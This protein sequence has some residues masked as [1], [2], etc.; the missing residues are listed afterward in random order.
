M[1]LTQNQRQFCKLVKQDLADY[2]G[3]VIL[4]KG[5]FV[6]G[7]SQCC[8]IFYFNAKS[9]PIIKVAM[10]KNSRDEW[11][12]VLVHEYAHFL[13]WKF[14]SKIWDKFQGGDFSFDTL[15]LDPIKNRRKILTMIELEMDCERKAISLIK[16]FKLCN[17]VRLYAQQANA[18]LYKY[19]Y[20]YKYARWPVAN[21]RSVAQNLSVAIL[22]TAKDYL[23][24][25]VELKDFL[26]NGKFAKV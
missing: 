16:R 19:A 6:G 5:E 25:P 9:E 24:I 14:A 22:P 12:G 15:I 11:F 26:S 2:D 10:G 23:S 8:G 20:L 18:V 3:K 13:Q 17:S 1:R 7:K 4:C 21:S